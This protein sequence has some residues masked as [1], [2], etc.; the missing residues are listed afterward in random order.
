[1]IAW[2]KCLLTG[3]N[4]VTR[5]QDESYPMERAYWE[6]YQVCLRCSADARPTWAIEDD[7]YI[8]QERIVM[9]MK[10]RKL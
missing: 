7:A 8:R 3:H 6:D 10:A 9:E 1:M 4:W 5:T 2:L